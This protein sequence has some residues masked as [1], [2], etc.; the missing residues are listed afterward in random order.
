MICVPYQV[1]PHF[2][3][4]VARTPTKGV[5]PSRRWPDCR[6]Y[7]LT[8]DPPGWLCSFITLADLGQAHEADHGHVRVLDLFVG[9][10]PALLARHCTTPSGITLRARE[11]SGRSAERAS[12]PQLSTTTVFPQAS[13]GSSFQLEMLGYKFQEDDQSHDPEGL[14]GR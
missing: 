10:R 8:L 2:E 3:Q 13:A 5:C 6:P 12:A 11:L 14:A 4:G 9:R 1:W 7:Q